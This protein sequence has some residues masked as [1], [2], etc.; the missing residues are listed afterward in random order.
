MDFIEQKALRKKYSTSELYVMEE[1]RSICLIRSAL[2]KCLVS[3]GTLIDRKCKRA[4]EKFAEKK[5]IEGAT[6]TDMTTSEDKKGKRRQ[7][8]DE[9]EKAV[10]RQR[11][12]VKSSE[13]VT[14]E[15]EVSPVTAN[16][17]KWPTVS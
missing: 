2:G 3:I 17:G 4:Q 13:Y 14:S 5:N 11:K 15:E 1:W 9:P 12:N 16:P 6:P 10:K 8:D 7:D